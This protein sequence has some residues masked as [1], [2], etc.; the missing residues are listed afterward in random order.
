M[1]VVV[2]QLFEALPKVWENLTGCSQPGS[3]S[4]FKVSGRQL[5]KGTLTPRLEEG[6]RRDVNAVADR[7]IET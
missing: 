5:S 2:W 4:I 1:A 7:G 3:G 6:D